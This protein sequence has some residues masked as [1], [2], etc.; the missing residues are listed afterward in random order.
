M[1]QD[2]ESSDSEVEDEEDAKQTSKFYQAHD[3]QEPDEEEFENNVEDEDDEGD[4]KNNTVV[5]DDNFD[6]D[7]ANTEN[8]VVNSYTLAKVYKYDIKGH[9]WC[10]ITF[11]VSIFISFLCLPC[12]F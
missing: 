8:A 10:S 3:E 4:E 11:A 9:T 1:T 2:Q 7:V 5:L 12:N 6:E